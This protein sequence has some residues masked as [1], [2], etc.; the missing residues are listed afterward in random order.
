MEKYI[1][2]KNKLREF[3]S[4]LRTKYSVYAPMEVKGG[5]VDF[6]LLNSPDEIDKAR[7]D[8]RTQSSPKK[9]LLPQREV[10]L[11]FKK[12]GKEL[13][14]EDCKYDDAKRIVLGTRPC[15]AVAIS[16]LDKVMGE[17][18]FKDMFYVKRRENTVIV[19]FACREPDPTC[20]CESVGGS[21]Y[22]KEGADA[23]FYDLGDRYYAESITERGKGLFNDARELVKKPASVDEKKKEE[24]EKGIVFGR[25][26]DPKSVEKLPAS[27]D[28]EYWRRVS[29][30]CLG[31]GVCTYFCPTCYCFDINDERGWKRVRTWDSC[32]FADFT[33]HTSGHNPRADRSK[34]LRNRFYHK[35]RYSGELFNRH[36]CVGCGRCI[37]LCPAGIDITK[38]INEVK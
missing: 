26:I 3:V 23:I 11:R 17:G 15:D 38:V 12:K 10:L 14:I 34:R 36:L 31:C 32:Q 20:F 2:D 24:F 37:S 13:K 27:F 22:S 16:M 29:R 8:C 35:F 30:A 19:S 7:L 28:S 25:K 4:K 9:F 6:A 33:M 21:P 1:L 18:L 5:E